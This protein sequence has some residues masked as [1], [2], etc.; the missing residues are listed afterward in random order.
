MELE[1]FTR[2]VQARGGE[3]AVW[4]VYLADR[5]ADLT[6]GRTDLVLQQA[7]FTRGHAYAFAEW[8]RN[9]RMWQHYYVFRVD[10]D[11]AWAVEGTVREGAFEMAFGRERELPAVGVTPAELASVVDG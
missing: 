4:L 1:A 6:E 11:L 8:R 9:A 7:F 5:F 10:A 2:E 3:C